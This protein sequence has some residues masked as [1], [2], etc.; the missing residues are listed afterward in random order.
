VPHG[1]P[2]TVS[3]ESPGPDGKGKARKGKQAMVSVVKLPDERIQ[4]AGDR[5]PAWRAI[6][7]SVGGSGSLV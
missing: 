4:P 1:A 6:S 2:A 3:S 5:L 7:S